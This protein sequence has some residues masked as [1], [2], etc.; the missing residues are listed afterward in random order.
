MRQ[1]PTVVNV[2]IQIAMQTEEQAKPSERYLFAD[3]YFSDKAIAIWQVKCIK[4]C[5]DKPRGH[6]YEKY[7]NWK[8]QDNEIAVFTLYA[9]ADFA[10]PKKFDIIFQTAIPDNYITTEY[11]L[12][13]SIHEAWFPLDSVDHGHKHLCIFR[14]DG[15]VPGI[16]NL[17]H[18]ANEKFSTSPKRQFKLGFCNSQ[19]FADI[20][21]V[22]E[23]RLSLKKQYG[24]NWWEFDTED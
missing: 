24:E 14:F 19:D 12:T 9:Y 5:K 6:A 20:K 17:L 4:R 18:K 10:I 21:R 1:A 16:F 3:E 11:E 23:R 15:E 7:V 13:Q 2:F 22:I 8:R